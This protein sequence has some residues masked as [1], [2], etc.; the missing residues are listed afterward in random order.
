MAENNKNAWAP[1]LLGE[2]SG[3]FAAAVITVPQAIGYGLIAFAALGPGFTADAALL[4]VYTTI[5]AGIVASLAGGTPIQITG[6][7]V[8]LTFIVAALAALLVAD[9]RLP[10]D[11]AQ[12]L[13]AVLALIAVCVFVAGAF[14]LLLGALRFGAVVKFVPYAVVSGFMNGVALLLISSQIKPLAGVAGE[15][16]LP[17]LVMNPGHISPAALAIGGLTIAVIYT[18]RRLSRT[19]PGPLV[20]LLVGTGTY[21]ALPAGVDAGPA[22]GAFAFAWPEFAL[23]GFGATA[24]RIEALTELL[25]VVVVSGLVLG[26]I[27][28]MESLMASLIADNLGDDQH[29]SNRELLGQGLGNVACSLFAALPAAGSVPRTLANFNA[30]G[31]TRVSGLLCGVIILLVIAEFGPLIGYL[32]LC[33]IAAVLVAVG[34]DLFDSWTTS[35]IRKLRTHAGHRREVLLELGVASAVAIVTVSV[36]LVAAVIFGLVITS[37]LTIWQLGKTVVHKRYS[38]AQVR[39]RRMRSRDQYALLQRE[40]DRIQILE[41]QGSLF[42]GSSDRLASEIQMAMAGAG[43]WCILDLK[44]ISDMDSTGAR[45]LLRIHKRLHRAGQ[46]LLVC[47]AD[48]QSAVGR[49]LEIMD[50]TEAIGEAG[51]FVD[52]D[53][54]LE[55]AENELLASSDQTLSVEEIVDFSALDL[56]RA[57]SADEMNTVA[58]YLVQRSFRAGETIFSEGEQTGDLFVVLKGTVT[59]T[60]D[61]QG[62]GGTRRLLTLGPG[63]VLGELGFMDGSSRSADCHA[64]DKASLLGLSAD[65]FREISDRSP[66]AARKIL[67]NIG[68]EIAQKLRRTTQV[69]AVFEDA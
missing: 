22:I 13:A 20:A 11:P 45:I 66:E 48:R 33:V 51:F 56:F 67:V 9:P 34:F 47:H 61:D 55:A 57:L 28:S 60:R 64:V 8:P 3:G 53:T 7:K 58:G 23:P 65:A 40:G 69:L 68:R 50:V 18:T 52:I 30:G 35:L 2:L 39:S 44:R 49:L 17:E 15:I 43:R 38:G 1:G 62:G 41:L 4:G 42:F 5:I 29:D 19:V 14:Q 36:N 27:A 26:L 31:R 32:P 46:R 37:A 6:P 59:I 25:P 63:G 16:G 12:K 24:P 10:Q 21:Y 54:A